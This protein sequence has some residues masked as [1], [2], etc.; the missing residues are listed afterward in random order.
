MIKVLVVDDSPTASLAIR[1]TL[2]SDREVHVVGE[3][4]NGDQALRLIQRFDP[5]IITMDVY[6]KRENG[7]DL[8]SSIM[9]YSPRPILIVTGIN[10]K[11]PQLMYRALEAGALDVTAKPSGPLSPRHQKERAHLV[12]LV[13]ILA[14][15]PVVHRF[16]PNGQG[17][18]KAAAPS[19][20][21]TNKRLPIDSQ[22]QSDSVP[23]I[24]G[25][26]RAKPVV[27]VGASTGGPNTVSFLLSQIPK[28]FHLPIVVIQHI[29]NGFSD[30]FAEWL[31]T[32]TQHRAMVVKRSTHLRCGEVYIAP[33]GNNLRFVSI[34]EIANSKPTSSNLNVPSFD[35]LLESAA[36]YA[37]PA[38]AIIMTGMGSDGTRGLRASRNTLAL[39]IAQAPESCV[40]DGMPS[41]AIS[42]H[43]IDQVMEPAQITT[44][45]CSLHNKTQRC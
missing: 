25:K 35:E 33:D 44:F 34:R 19:A 31:S 32:V 4:E 11:D 41:S 18:I 23:E 13:K 8:T 16:S 39:T 45:L 1:Q 14:K 20:D 9:A 29:S 42:A 28:P 3:A 10:P 5:H 2:E 37:I 15:V 17:S 12:R 21:R 36:I 26:R 27:L 22:V 40:V 38:V 7:I 24:Y 30:S 6:L 43:L